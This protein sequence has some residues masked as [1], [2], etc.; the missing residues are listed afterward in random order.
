[1]R[2]FTFA[3]ATIIS[4]SGVP[5]HAE[6]TDERQNQS[7]ESKLLAKPDAFQTLVNPRCS[8]CV[9]E[10]KRRAGELSD[11]D[12][13]LAWIRGYSQG[14]GIPLRFFLVPYRVI[15]DTYGVFVYDPDA[16]FMRGFEPSLDF[17][18][19]GWRNG[20]MVMRHKDGTL[21][22]C[23]SGHA[24]DG[25]RK[26]HQLK[27]VPT[28]ETEWGYWLNAYPGA[29]AYHMFEKYQPIELPRTENNDSTSTRLPPDPRLPALAP[30]MGIARG[31]RAK[32]YPI[33]AFQQKRAAIVMDSIGEAQIV[34]LWYGPTRTAAIYSP[35]VDDS[36][37]PQRVTLTVDDAAPTAPF[38]DRETGSH[39][40]IAGRAVDGP[41]QGKTLRWLPG[42]VCRWFAWAAEYPETQVYAAADASAASPRS[43][44]TAAK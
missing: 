37:P 26:G 5:A 25:P 39:W 27:P 31:G 21:Y 1:M 4:A 7:S 12:R 13:V 15:S 42:V 36:D 41:L 20:I 9:D 8:H 44:S 43:A 14:G 29:V 6:D 33:A 32:A 2:L 30:V 35:E 22:S 24:F 17:E 19:Y 16:G 40:D 11:D 3:A 38:L 10:A 28:L 34:A 18:F 23:L